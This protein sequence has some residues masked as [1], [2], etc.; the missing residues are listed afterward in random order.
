MS[1]V[2]HVIHLKG[3]HCDLFRQDRFA[4]ELGD[5]FRGKLIALARGSLSPKAST[6]SWP[7]SFRLALDVVVGLP[8]FGVG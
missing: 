1:I 2:G 7:G 5:R 4:I 6:V 3:L 8:G